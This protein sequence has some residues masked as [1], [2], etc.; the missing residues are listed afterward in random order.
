MQTLGME[1]SAIFIGLFLSLSLCELNSALK[2]STG[3]TEEKC[4]AG[5]SS[6]VSSVLCK[7][8]GTTRLPVFSMDGDYVIG[9]VF[10]IHHYTHTPVH[11]YTTM[12]EPLKCTGRL[13]RG[14]SGGYEDVILYGVRHV[15]LY[16]MLQSF[17]VIFKMLANICC[18][19]KIKNKRQIKPFLNYMF[20]I[21]KYVHYGLISNPAL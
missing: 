21:F 7:L 1:I 8:R 18:I 14:Q 10:A 11:N 9:G 16:M 2:Q 4:C 6:E 5:V 17:C 3:L 20:T 19:T 12:P 15:L 13:V